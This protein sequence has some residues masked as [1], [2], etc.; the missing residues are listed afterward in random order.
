MKRNSEPLLNVNDK[1]NS[2]PISENAKYDNNFKIKQTIPNSFDWRSFNGHTYIGPIRDQGDCGS[3]Y[4]FG[5]NAAAEGAFNV[6]TGSFDT[7]CAD[8]SESFIIWC[9]GS[10]SPYSSHFYGCDGADYTKAELQALCDSGVCLESSF[11]YTIYEPGSCTHWKDPRVKMNNWFRVPCSDT[12]A[13]K[14]A[15]LSYGPVEAFVNVT[16][17]FEYYT[18]GVFS[19]TQNSCDGSPCSFT[20]INHA[21][22]IV[23]WGHDPVKGLYWILRNSWGPSWG[24]SGYMRIKWNSARILCGVAYFQYSNKLT[25]TTLSAS[26]IGNTSASLNGLVNPNGKSSN[27]YFDYGTTVGYGK[28]TTVTSAGSG[29]SAV[30][31]SANVTGLTGGTT[32]HYRIVASNI[33]TIIY[34]NDLTFLTC[35]TSPKMVLSNTSFNFG[36]VLQNGSITDTL[37][38]YNNSCSSNLIISNITTS[39]SEFKVN[40]TTLNISA[41]NT[42]T[43]Y[44]TF[45]PKSLGNFNGNLTIYSNDVDTVLSLSGNGV[46]PPVISVTPDSLREDLFTGGTSTKLLT[47][48][49]NGGSDLIYSISTSKAETNKKDGLISNKVGQPA[50]NKNKIK[51]LSIWEANG[52]SE[53]RYKDLLNKKNSVDHRIVEKQNV[54]SESF[55]NVTVEDFETG[56]WP[57]DPWVTVYPGGETDN[58]CA[59]EGNRGISNPE[60]HYRNDFT[61]GDP[62]E[63]LSIWIKFNDYGRFYLGFGANSGGC[64]SLVAGAN[65]NEFILQNNEYY[66][67]E[68]VTSVYQEYSLDTWYKIEVVF[69]DTEDLQF[70]LYDSD[71]STLLNSFSYHINGFVKDGIAIRGFGSCG[72]LIKINSQDLDW[73]TEEPLNGIIH[74]GNSEDISVKFNAKGLYGG[75]YFANIG[76]TTNDPL[77]QNVTVPAHLHVTG[78]PD[79]SIAHDTLNFST[80]FIGTSFTDTL[81]ISNVGTDILTVNDISANNSDY[82][83]DTTSFSLNPGQ[84]HNVLVTFNPSTEGKILAT[85]T[86][87]SNDPVE[88]SVSV[89][90]QGE[91]KFPPV[92]SV[93]PDSLSENLLTGE[94]STQLLTISNSGK[95]DLDLSLSIANLKAVSMSV[96]PHNNISLKDSENKKNEAAKNKNAVSIKSQ[97]PT[98]NKLNPSSGPLMLAGEY[99]G[100]NLYFGISNYGEIMPFQYPIGTEHL[101]VGTYISGYTLAY[102]TGGYDNLAYTSY[103]TRSGITP[104]SYKELV[105]NSSQL[106][107]EVVTQTSD[108]YL[109]ITRLFTFEK[110]DKYIRTQTKLENISGIEVDSIVFKEYADWDV[111]GTYNNDNWDY[112]PLRNM[113]YAYDVHYVTIASQK[114]PDRRDIDGWDDYM[115]RETDEDYIVGPVLMFDGLELLHYEL[116]NMTVG[117]TN[118]ITTAYGAGDNLADLQSVIDRAF[119]GLD[120]LSVDPVSDTVPSDSSLQIKVTFDAKGLNGGDYD[121]NIVIASNDPFHSEIRTPAHLHVTGRPI[122]EVSTDTLNFGHVFT[123]Y[124]DTMSVS[125]RNK[126]TDLLVVDSMFTT[127]VHFGT[128]NKKLSIN[129]NDSAIIKVWY[130][131]NELQSDKGFLKLFSNDTLN[132]PKSIVLIGESLLPPVISVLPDSFHITLYPGDTSMSYLTIGNTINNAELEA[133]LSVGYNSEKALNIHQKPSQI[134]SSTAINTDKN[135]L[136]V[137]ITGNTDILVIQDNYAWGLMMSD[138]INNNFALV[139]DVINSNLIPV[140]DF[141][142]YNLIIVTGDQ[143]SYYYY[144]ISSYKSK[145]EEFL[146]N[147]GTIQ[148]QLATQGDNI[149]LAGGIEM[150]FGY[151]QDYNLSVLPGHPIL[152]GLPKIL[153]GNFVSHCYIDST[154]MPKNTKIL[155]TT[156]NEGLPTTIEYN[157]GLGKVIATGMTW[158][159]LYNYNYVAGA[160]LYNATKYSITHSGCSWI[161]T[162]TNTFKI[163]GINQ[164]DVPV[165]FSAKNLSSGDYYA[166]IIV[167]SNDPLHPMISVPAHLNVLPNKPYIKKEIGLL[168]VNIA[169][170]TYHIMLDS[171]FGVPS[172]EPLS[173]SQTLSN[174]VHD[175]ASIGIVDNMLSIDPLETGKGLLTITAKTKVDDTV[176]MEINVKVYRQVSINDISESELYLNNYPNPFDNITDICYNLDRRAY[177]EIRIYDLQGQLLNTLVNGYKDEGK[178]IQEFNANMLKPGVYIYELR[179]DGAVS[180]RNRMIIE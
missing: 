131:A 176:N 120:W 25:A 9:L 42:G 85:M 22:S 50:S 58:S 7:K 89:T 158:E 149:E 129:C 36:D 33:D 81:V 125:I 141:S 121:G 138:F 105:N 55:I 117:K 115:R 39:L 170:G 178:Q 60:W 2:N 71:G 31:V 169:G 101:A 54:K 113:I 70:N 162:S 65:T 11:P 48:S 4:S 103:Y 97:A 63:N 139:P 75:G 145:F 132:T 80:H 76:I 30:S 96:K 28:S 43:V 173:Y 150:F 14:S 144:M 111:D 153:T 27:Y 174:T 124:T 72:D 68:N 126:G 104:I 23:G 99:S 86:I 79:I 143:S 112:D 47:I 93:T 110:G 20:S 102:F 154:T 66:E 168:L 142:K 166:S 49:N 6:A 32:Y 165:V 114:A 128:N 94:K 151:Q 84:R 34:G 90:L 88:S 118:T 82:S 13:I 52:I 69:V 135:S 100:D 77:D 130:N 136:P 46:P 177:V 152:E 56:V 157:Y 137:K 64:Y 127:D 146:Q 29:T 45:N 24:E 171:L 147:G 67:F 91:G 175:I 133:E 108:G 19:D 106:I 109:R 140:T 148:Y 164:T 134:I 35:T 74:A 123:G 179:V 107:V 172:G 40:K 15:I 21:I 161:I 53:A 10:I 5:A 44:I 87:S 122:I 98:L 119:I 51:K 16:F 159:Y 167:N 59:Y 83:I 12:T 61:I 180:G 73:I 62:K 18:N 8:F 163:D 1:R 160:M 116:G 41:G 155:T 95:S 156:Y 92:I 57:W 26:G 17:D 37:S 78:A 3:C 38:I